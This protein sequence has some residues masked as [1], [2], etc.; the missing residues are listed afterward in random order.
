MPRAL[1]IAG[2]WLACAVLVTSCA[3]LVGT[4]AQ[5]DALRA[6]EPVPDDDLFQ[7]LMAADPNLPHIDAET[8]MILT[9]SSGP[10]QSRPYPARAAKGLVSEEGSGSH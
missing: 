2:L 10:T 6:G 8:P 4:P 1:S 7:R 5:R 9:L 3:S